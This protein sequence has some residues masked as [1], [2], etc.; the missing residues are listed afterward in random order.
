MSI[1][2]KVGRGTW[3][4]V[5]VGMAVCNSTLGTLTNPF[6]KDD[7]RKS[8]SERWHS[9]MEY[10]DI[11]LDEAV[12]NCSECYSFRGS[13]PSTMNKMFRAGDKLPVSEFFGYG[14]PVKDAP[15]A[16]RDSHCVEHWDRV[17]KYQHHYRNS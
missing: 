7:K 12:R 9:S 3:K 15:V 14:S 4:T 6:L 16:E 11:D 1:K 13:K 2:T 5:T 8:P 17:R 10:Y